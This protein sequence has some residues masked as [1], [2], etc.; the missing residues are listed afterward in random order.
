MVLVEQKYYQNCLPLQYHYDNQRNYY[1]IIN[2]IIYPIWCK[3]HNYWANSEGI[4]DVQ[5]DSLDPF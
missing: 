2:K 5:T 4:E 1:R 3:S